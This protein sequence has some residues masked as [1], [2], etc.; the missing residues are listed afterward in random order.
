MAHADTAAT[1]APALSPSAPLPLPFGSLL[2]RW[3]QGRGWSQLALAERADTSARHLSFMETGRASPSREMVLRLAE[4]L[5]I[6]LRERNAMLVAA[7]YAPMYKQRA[8]DDP[9]LASA[10]QAVDLV[11]RAHE[12]FPA[13]AID[14]HWQLVAMNRAVGTLLA[15]LPPQVLQPPINVLRLSLD[16][17]GLA[18]RIVNLAQWRH[19]LLERLRQ[20][21]ETNGDPVL[22]SLLAELRAFP[23]L[24]GES[25]VQ[26]DGEHAGLVVP[27]LLRSPMGP[28]SF[29]S[30]TTVFGTPIDVTVQELAI[31][32]LLPADEATAQI[33]RG[34]A[35]DWA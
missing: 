12:P 2:R 20:Q 10:R 30:T 1:I 16:P 35:S 11:L 33:L 17:Q 6:P 24:P 19:H 32:T 8:L 25:S 29:I 23:V 34:L 4:R 26:L 3:R 7:G 5:G 13:L 31:E 28:L 9:A 27:L 14:R 18:P 21:T 15:E 22:T